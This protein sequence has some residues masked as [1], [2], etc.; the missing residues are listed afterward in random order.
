MPIQKCRRKNKSGWRYGDSGKCYLG[1][2][3]KEKAKKQGRAISLSKARQKG[4]KIPEK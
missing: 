3:A 1:P 4:H 2:N